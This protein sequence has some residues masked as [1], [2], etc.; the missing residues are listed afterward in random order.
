M[1]GQTL[2]DFQKTRNAQIA[3]SVAGEDLGE[4][5]WDKPGRAAGTA[6]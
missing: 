1:R 4:L 3:Y 5:E 2:E 6:R